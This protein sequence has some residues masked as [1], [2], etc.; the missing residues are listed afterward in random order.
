MQEASAGVCISVGA[1]G[2]VRDELVRAGG[3]PLGLAN[4]RCAH[5]GAPHATRT[6]AAAVAAAAAAAATATATATA[7]AAGAAAAAAAATA[8]AAVGCSAVATQASSTPVSC[9]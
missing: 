4:G 3:K 2:E 5:K 7:A 9:F 1:A 8:V 6:L